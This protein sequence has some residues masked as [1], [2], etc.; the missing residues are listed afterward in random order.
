MKKSWRKNIILKERI[1]R[2]L[3]HVDDW[4]GSAHT[5]GSN[6]AVSFHSEVLA[7]SV[8]S[9][10]MGHWGT[11]PL[12]FANFADLT[13]DGFHFWMTL[14]PRTSEPVRHAPVP[15]GAKFWR[16]H[17]THFLVAQHYAAAALW[18]WVL[19][20]LTSVLHYLLIT[21]PLSHQFWPFQNFSFL[22]YGQPWD[23]ID[24]PTDRL[25]DRRGAIRNVASHREGRIITVKGW[26]HGAT[27]ATIDCHEW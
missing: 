4:I 25:T 17:W 27:A 9:P 11:C 19:N 12:E 22:N 3:G 20:L 14:S 6:I 23:L 18:P 10:A 5:I 13:P 8:A 16:R 7:H 1:L 21:W 24:G 15:P 2:W 26:I